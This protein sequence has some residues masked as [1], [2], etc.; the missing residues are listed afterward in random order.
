MC[1]PGVSPL[2]EEVRTSG[3]C[4]PDPLPP[5]FPLVLSRPE[6]TDRLHTERDPVVRITAGCFGALISSKLM[7]ALNLESTISLGDPVHDEELACISAILATGYSEDLL[8]PHQLRIIN[9]EK[10]VSIMSGEIDVL[11]TA[12]GAPARI[13]DIAQDTLNILADRLID[14]NFVPQSLP[15]EQQRLLDDIS[16]EV[17]LWS[18]DRLKDQV[19]NKL[20]RL[21]QILENL[22]PEVGP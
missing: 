15:L 7:D 1:I 3:H 2:S 22:L 20:D 14:S 8:L 5:Y 16:E 4:A 10:I 17:K 9:F 19:V 21:Q 11:F 6:L 12:E 13:L 18:T